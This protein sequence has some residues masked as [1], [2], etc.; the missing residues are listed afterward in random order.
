MRAPLAIALAV[1]VLPLAASAIGPPLDDDAGSGRD[2]PEA[3]IDDVRIEPG[4]VHWGNLTGATLDPS[5]WFA[6]P[7]R[8]GDAV[9]ARLWADLACLEIATPAGAVIADACGTM[10]YAFEAQASAVAPANGVVFVVVR[11]YL[12]DVTDAY[13][14]S[15][16]VNAPAPPTTPQAG[17]D[18]FPAPG[19]PLQP[20]ALVHVEGGSC[21]LNF[22][23]ADARDLYVGTAGHCAARVGERLR[24]D[25]GREFGS[26]VA[27]FD[28]AATDF[29]L[30]RI[31][32][33]FRAMARADV[34]H[35]G[36]PTGVARTGAPGDVLAFYGYGTGFDA[37]EATRPRAGVLVRHDGAQYAADM[38]AVFGDSGAPILHRAT[39]GALGIVSR[40]NLVDLPPTT[41]EGPTVAHALARLRAVGFAV[42][43]VTAPLAAATTPTP[44]APDELGAEP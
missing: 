29:A 19:S 27:D 17:L 20:G 11:A 38:P 5:D 41:D 21:T 33:A 39:G 8:A 36:G 37:S 9:S 12:D 18:P 35:W 16:G 43:L 30:V 25:D 6:L 7:V 24:L 26:V 34:R 32:D 44:G 31:D 4:R 13:R 14:V 2:A 15:A 10:A 22:L 42:D 28:D 3:P 40:F 23:F 1:A